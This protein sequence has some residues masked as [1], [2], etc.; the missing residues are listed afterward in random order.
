MKKKFKIL[1]V[2]IQRLIVLHSIHGSIIQED[3]YLAESSPILSNSTNKFK[4]SN[5][6]STSNIV[7]SSIFSSTSS[8]IEDDEITLSPV[9]PLFASPSLEDRKEFGDDV[10]ENGIRFEEEPSDSYIVRSKSATLRC[11]TLNALNAW[12]TC[13]SGDERRTQSNQKISNY[14]NPQTGI[15]LIEIDL[16]IT[17]SDV[18]EHASSGYRN[19]FQCWCTAYGGHHQIMSRK[20][21]ISFAFLEK[22]FSIQPE[23][24]SV[25]LNAEKKDSV[26]RFKCDPPSGRPKPIVFWMKNDKIIL[27]TEQTNPKRKG[28][29]NSNQ[30]LSF[31]IEDL[32]NLEN[33][34]NKLAKRFSK[35]KEME[36]NHF[37]DAID[38]YEE[39]EN[40]A[41]T[42]AE[43]SE[44]D[45]MLFGDDFED[46]ELEIRKRYRN[47]ETIRLN[48]F[49]LHSDSLGRSKEEQD[50]HKLFYDR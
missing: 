39:D 44:I 12:F 41:E 28:R 46:E 15:R 37:V 6:F 42:E 20:A 16:V 3:I 4:S 8:S 45:E 32:D 1:F 11:R 17:R 31:G 18:E 47:D 34:S 14:V 38:D 29:K 48:N 36:E 40:V 9:I 27:A 49:D 23:S 10:V 35:K 19:P 50:A 13:N 30:N 43:E 7:T 24:V 25:I 26:I 33:G 22:H 21:S 2:L 5:N